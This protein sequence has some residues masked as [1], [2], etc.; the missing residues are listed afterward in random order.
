MTR[1]GK[2][3]RSTGS[4]LSAAPY[5]I[6]GL[7][8]ASTYA[9]RSNDPFAKGSGKGFSTGYPSLDTVSTSRTRAV[10]GRHRVPLLREKQ[11]HRPDHG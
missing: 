4:S 5:P 1:H 11:L 2:P 6:A 10:D 7:S 3:M 8:D 9:E